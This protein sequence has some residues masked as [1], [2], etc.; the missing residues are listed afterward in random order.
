MEKG[1]PYAIDAGFTMCHLLT[2]VV[3]PL[4]VGY[5]IKLVECPKKQFDPFERRYL[6]EKIKKQTIGDA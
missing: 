5:M 6:I 4:L 2:V 1:L 3:S